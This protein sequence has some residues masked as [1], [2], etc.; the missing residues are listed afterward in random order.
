[1]RTDTMSRKGRVAD[2]C[3]SEVKGIQK[4]R[5]EFID[6]R[7]DY[8]IEGDAHA[9]KW[10]RQVSL[11]A[12]ESVSKLRDKI[13][14]DFPS[15]AF[16]ENILTEGIE[17][18]TIPVGSEIK[19]GEALCEVTQIGKECHQDCEI[20]RICGDCVMPREGIFVKVLKGGR[21]K[22]GDDIVLQE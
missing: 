16:A 22:A 14:Y 6:L 17:L 15:G 4:H 1:M 8:G 5:V 7:Q 2:V 19:I 9:G 10:H 3:I 13:D 18:Y 12:A 20:R 11:L 21:V